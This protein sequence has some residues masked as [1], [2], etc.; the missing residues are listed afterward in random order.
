MNALKL[1]FEQHLQSG[2]VWLQEKVKIV[3]MPGDRGEGGYGEVQRIRIARM[4]GIPS[5]IDFTAK[6][7]KVET[8]FLQRHA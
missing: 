4:A 2:V 5:D 8:P 7:S 6:K 1:A 3:E